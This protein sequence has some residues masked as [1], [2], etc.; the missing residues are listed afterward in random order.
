MRARW[1][2]FVE[3]YLTCWNATEAAA[4][5]GYSARSAATQGARLLATPEIQAALT[6]RLDEKAMS[7]DEVIARLTEQARA[8][9][10]DFITRQADG[11]WE[12]Q[13]P[14]EKAHLVK[15]FTP[16][17]GGGK[18]ELYDAQAALIQLGKMHG[19]F[20]EINEQQGEIAIR[21]IRDNA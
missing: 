15:T 1:R 21:V 19:L 9:I 12:L 8:S 7:A 3:E 2:L 6:A 14:V 11:T 20:R 16:M 18:V 10:A 5:A 17:L 13:L 4:R